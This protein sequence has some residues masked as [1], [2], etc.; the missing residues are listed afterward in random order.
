[1]KRLLDL[2]CGAGGAGMGYYRA[3]FEVVGVDIKPQKHY[4]FEFHQ[5][6][7]LEYLAE[8]GSEFDVI[9]ASPP[10][11]RYSQITPN[12]YRNNWPDL[13]E[14]TR[15]AIAGFQ[16]LYI[17]ENVSGARKLLIDP[18]QLCG[19]MFGLQ[20]ERHRYFE[21]VPR[22]EILL[23]PCNHSGHKVYLNGCGHIRK[24]QKKPKSVKLASE[25]M[26]IYWMTFDELRE[27]IPP[28]YT[29]WIGKRIL[30]LL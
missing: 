15:L 13:I 4:P 23:S 28:A 24:G 19:S 18:I 21:I 29:E 8:H 14:K 27:A 6:D 20:V 1:V 16:K 25:A 30:G 7:A 9:H 10:C 11:Q 3:G 26:G 12:K 17:I 22:P 2:F 5:A